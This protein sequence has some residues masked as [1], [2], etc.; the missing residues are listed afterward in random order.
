MDAN[1]F[2]HATAN[3]DDG[4]STSRSGID[5][6]FAPIYIC[7]YIRIFLPLWSRGGRTD[8]QRF[9]VKKN[10]KRKK[11]KVLG[12]LRWAFVR[13]AWQGAIVSD[14]G[15]PC[16]KNTRTE[17]IDHQTLWILWIF[18]FRVYA[19][20]NKNKFFSFSCFEGTEKC[21]GCVRISL[22]F[23][24][25]WIDK[26]PARESWYV[27]TPLKK[28][29]VANSDA[30]LTIRPRNVIF[31]PLFLWKTDR[32]S[33]KAQRAF[34]PQ[35]PE[36]FKNEI[37]FFVNFVGHRRVHVR[38]YCFRLHVIDGV[39]AS[40][41]SDG[42]CCRR[43]RERPQERHEVHVYDIRRH[44]QGRIVSSANDDQSTSM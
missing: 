30:G 1:S 20:Q 7:I 15:Q 26:T 40:Q 17:D 25:W 18:F 34:V 2:L 5:R 44:K 11:K 35:S 33:R 16:K 23:D 19:A 13:P 8:K 28:S 36:T 38:L 22:L 32:N 37:L 3:R 9:S 31:F 39:R 27:E 43:R 29:M 4:C 6:S 41:H 42:R 14:G 21:F 12:H 24:I 10:I